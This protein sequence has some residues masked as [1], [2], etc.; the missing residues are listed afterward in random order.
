MLREGWAVRVAD[1]GVQGAGGNAAGIGGLMEIAARGVLVAII[2][3][4]C[5]A[6]PMIMLLT[7]DM[8]DGPRASLSG[9]LMLIALAGNFLIGLPISLLVFRYLRRAEQLTMR[10][11]L[12]LA[13]VTSSVIVFALTAIGGLFV[14]IFYG[15]PIFIAANAFAIA[16]WFIVI[17]PALARA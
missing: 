5:S 2:A 10:R 3:A 6:M 14:T 7:W 12:L 8:D 11:L 9:G 1:A 15:I 13:N 4:F 16:G 17:K